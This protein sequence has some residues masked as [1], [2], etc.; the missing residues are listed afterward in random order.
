M[1]SLLKPRATVP[2]QA[3]ETILHMAYL[4]TVCYANNKALVSFF[5]TLMIVLRSWRLFC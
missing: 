4:Q 3:S 2:R 1:L 5:E